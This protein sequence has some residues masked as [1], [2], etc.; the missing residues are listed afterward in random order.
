MN[1][2]L[3]KLFKHPIRV[4]INRI[5]VFL[6]WFRYSKHHDYKAEYFWKNT[7]KKYGF[8]LRGVG[9]CIKSQDENQRILNEGSRLMLE[10]CNR[11]GIDLREVS[12]LDVGCGTGYYSRPFIEAGGTQYTGIDIVD[13]LFDGLQKRFT[14]FKF[15]QIDVSTTPIQGEYNLIIAMDVLQHITNETKFRFAMKN[16]KSHLTKDGVIIISTCIG[17]FKHNS[18]YMVTRPMSIFQDVFQRYR[19]SKSLDLYGNK[20]FS[21]RKV[22]W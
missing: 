11:E 6:K 17:P 21:I 2:K 12:L 10:L 13:T 20:M 3:I 8:D 22:N 16:I 19:I 5:Y 7:H 15:L 4:V 9:S 14:D 1:K 18:F